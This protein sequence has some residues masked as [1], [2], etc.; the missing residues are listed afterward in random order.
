MEG[1]LL[2]VAIFLI[3]SFLNRAKKTKHQKPM[4]PFNNKPNPQMFDLPKQEPRKSTTKSLE[5]FA[6]EIFQ[7]LNENVSSQTFEKAKEKFE[8]KKTHTAVHEVE[9][10]PINQNS[11]PS[12]DVN[13]SIRTTTRELT[14]NGST[15]NQNEIGSFVPTSREALMQAIIA[16]EILGPPKSK[17]RS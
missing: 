4:P 10:N 15:V 14:S 11:R 17:Q 5:D 16:S 2:M 6:S 9:K 1:I 12:L 8:E 3:S 7:K 13:R